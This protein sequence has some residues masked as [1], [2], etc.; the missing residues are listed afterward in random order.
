[1]KSNI[2]IAFLSFL[3]ISVSANTFAQEKNGSAV[4]VQP[5]V[6]FFRLHWLRA[7]LKKPDYPKAAKDA[8]ITGRVEVWVEVDENGVVTSARPVSGPDQLK[9]VSIAAAHQSKFKPDE[10]QGKKYKAA[11]WIDFFFPESEE[12]EYTDS[13][14][15]CLLSEWIN[16]GSVGIPFLTD[17][18]MTEVD[19]IDPTIFKEVMESD[20]VK[21]AGQN[22]YI[23][24]I[25]GVTAKLETRM[26]REKLWYF[27]FGK[28]LGKLE[29]TLVTSGS[30]T[31]LRARLNEIKEHSKTMPPDFPFFAKIELKSL[32][33]LL[34]RK[35]LTSEEAKKQIEEDAVHMGQS[36]NL[37]LPNP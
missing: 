22:M 18:W 14:R 8:N 2:T 25:D 6:G 4:K 10:F 5:D 34:D 27:Q 35:E 26:T 19:K 36:L 24:M 21:N 12:K 15:M 32:L 1:M 37:A 11:G 16:S 31:D 9:E 29:C 17:S 33:R 20:A 28:K 3:M 30:E 13:I 23:A 7:D